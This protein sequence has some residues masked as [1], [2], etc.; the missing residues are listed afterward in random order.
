MLV[1]PILAD[2]YVRLRH[3]IVSLIA[4]FVYAFAFGLLGLFS[5]E[6]VVVDVLISSFSFYLLSVVSWYEFAFNRLESLTFF[7]LVYI[8]IVYALV[9]VIVVLLLE[10]MV[11]LAVFHELNG[12]SVNVLP[13]RCLVLILI[14]LVY[15]QYLSSIKRMSEDEGK[16]DVKKNMYMEQDFEEPVKKIERITVRI[17]HMIEM[18]QL[19]D[20]IYMKAEDDYVSVVTLKGSYLKSERLKYYEEM[21][22]SEMFVRVH[23]SYIVNINKIVKIER[24]G[25]KQ[26]LLL[27]SGETIRISVSGYRELKVNL[28]L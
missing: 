3:I 5:V 17:G 13:A 4:G 26:L 8:R 23:R 1:N 12:M 9:S 24:Y 28:N 10:V 15:W 21:L 27:S 25:Q 14:Y 6:S 16:E 20:I 7:Q 11:H 19:E 18:I 22:P 2:S